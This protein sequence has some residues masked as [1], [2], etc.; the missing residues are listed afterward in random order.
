M[1]EELLED[2]DVKR[3]ARFG[4]GRYLFNLMFLSSPSTTYLLM[5][6]LLIDDI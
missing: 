5:Y 3:V 2:E 1:I 4:S 6:C